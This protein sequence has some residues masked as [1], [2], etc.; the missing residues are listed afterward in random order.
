[1]T[2]LKPTFEDAVLLLADKP[3]PAFIAANAT[4][5]Y[6]GL[7]DLAARVANLEHASLE[8]TFRT[9][10]LEDV[11][12]ASVTKLNAIEAERTKEAQRLDA[13]EKAP[14]A[15]D[16]RLSDIDTRVRTVEGAVGSA[17]YNTTLNKPNDIKPS[18]VKPSDIKPGDPANKSISPLPGSQGGPSQ[19]PSHTTGV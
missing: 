11:S 19:N 12:N 2:A 10:A 16:K 18:D 15:N 13:V 17:N 1:M 5:L 8:A 9:A 3:T 6:A 7:N 4:I 14:A